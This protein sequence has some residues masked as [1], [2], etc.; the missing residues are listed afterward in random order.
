MKIS[1]L[2]NLLSL[3]PLY[4]LYS[5]EDHFKFPFNKRSSLHVVPLLV[6]KE[7]VYIIGGIII[8][9]NHLTD[10]KTDRLRTKADHKIYLPLLPVYP[11]TKGSKTKFITIIFKIA[12]ITVKLL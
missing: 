9:F 2:V 10:R 3:F 6:V 12:D 11:K 5:E 7:N 1:K 4:F 8:I